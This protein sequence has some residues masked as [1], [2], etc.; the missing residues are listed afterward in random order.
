MKIMMHD[1]PRQKLCELINCH[2][3][4]LCEDAKRCESFLRDVCTSKY[5]R[6]VFVLINAIKEGVAKDLLNPPRGL[7]NEALFARLIQRLHDNLALDAVA[8]EWAV[9]SWSIAL[10]IQLPKPKIK[11][12]TKLRRFNKSL[13][14]F[15]LP[16]VQV[17][18]QLKQIV[19]PAHAP[20][21][22]I[23]ASL[24]PLSPFKPADY[25]RLLGWVLIKPQKLQAYR[26]KFGI[27]DEQRVGKW[28]AS[29]LLWGPLL[30]STFILGI[31]G[32]PHSAP[33]PSTVYLVLSLL[34]IFVWFLTVRLELNPSHNLGLTI[35]FL[36]AFGSALTI[37]VG[38]IDVVVL[39]IVQVIV[40]VMAAGV[41]E[42][43]GGI[44]RLS[45]V[46]AIGATLGMTLGLVGSM[47]G[48]EAGAIAACE[49]FIGT[50]VVLGFMGDRI[51]N[52]L[53]NGK[54]SV[55]TRLAFGLLTINYMI[56]FG[57]Y[58]TQLFSH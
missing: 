41:A 43:I 25:L 42:C 23:S 46:V 31:E 55:F 22:S 57:F 50:I 49:A 21:Q 17:A 39:G 9:Y 33:I 7:P 14:N 56:F 10:G 48:H 34:L 2:G 35:A 29:S 1:L 36:L 58:A 53:K 45:S 40:I 24:E 5:N 26:H 13:K 11:K 8:A 20:S 30:I 16:T 52:S 51:E 32:L 47:M 12:K 38:L 3:T 15:Q 28:L 18:E 27:E 44:G 37:A 4:I 19:N 6:E 54:S